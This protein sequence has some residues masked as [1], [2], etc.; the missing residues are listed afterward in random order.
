MKVADIKC[1]CKGTDTGSFLQEGEYSG[2]LSS[3]DAFPADLEAQ[4]EKLKGEMSGG[5]LDAN[6]LNLGGFSPLFEMG[7]TANNNIS[8]ANSSISELKEI[9]QNDAKTHMSN[10]WGKYYQEVYKCTEEKRQ[11]M[12]SAQSTYNSVVNNKDSSQSAINSAASALEDAKDDYEKHQKELS[13]ASSKYESYAGSGAASSALDVDFEAMATTAATPST[14]KSGYN[15]DGSAAQEVQASI[16]DELSALGYSRAGICAILANMQQESGFD[17]TAVGDGGTSFGLCQWHD[18]RWSNLNSFCEQNGLDPNSVKGQIAFL[19][20]ELKNNY[21]TLYEGLQN[22]DDTQATAES[23]A[24]TW[25]TDFERPADA[26]T[27]ASERASYV[28][29]YWERSEG[30]GT[31]ASVISGYSYL[32][33]MDKSNNKKTQA[34]KERDYDTTASSGQSSASREVAAQIGSYAANNCPGTTGWCAGAVETAVSAITGIDTSGNAEDLLTNGSLENAGYVRQNIDPGSSDYQ[35]LPGDIVVCN[36]GYASS[37][38]Y[39]EYGHAQVYT[40]D[41]W[42]SDHKQDSMYLYSNEN[43]LFRYEGKN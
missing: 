18:S 24:R 10:E 11:A 20:Y 31:G 8:S 7:Y 40:E 4:E 25:C 5:G 22:G 38:Y 9:V 16:Y 13:N 19:D 42:Y 12:E 41:G 33:G 26:E 35:P 3:L 34:V 37:G 14:G 15:S 23:L 30:A 1:F 32:S 29:T 39:S 17:L 27:R 43:V 36:E 6:A 2:V 28:G 21:P